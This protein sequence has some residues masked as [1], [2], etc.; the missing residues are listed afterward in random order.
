MLH[1]SFVPDDKVKNYF[2][3]ADFLVLPYK[4]AT[5]SGVTQIA[6]KFE[7]PVVVTDVGGLREIITHERNGYLTEPTAESL[8]DAIERI[9][10]EETISKMRVAMREDSK[11]FSWSEMCAKMLQVFRATKQ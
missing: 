11:R 10:N 5:Q 9:S 1:D 7:L 3:A 6:Y 8:A 4:T 2:S